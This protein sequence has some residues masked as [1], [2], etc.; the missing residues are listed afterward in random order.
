VS[1]FDES[2]R[3]L[4]KEI[5]YK[6]EALNCIRFR[7]NFADTPWVKVPEVMLNMTTDKVVVMEYVPGIKINDLKR[8]DEAKIDR[9]LLAKRSAE[10]YLTQLCRHGFFHCDRELLLFWTSP[11]LLALLAH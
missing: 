6:A 8:I 3:L 9:S 7:E 2:A 11:F 4:Y 1:I 10:A 5:D